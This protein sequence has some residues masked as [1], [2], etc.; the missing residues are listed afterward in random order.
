VGFLFGKQKMKSL[1]VCLFSNG[2]IKVGRGTRAEKRIKDHRARGETMG[3]EM[4]NHFI[5]ECPG[6]L[7]AA[8]CALI[9]WCSERC[10]KRMRSE[11]FIGVDYAQAVDKAQELAA[12]AYVKTQEEI[13]AG[14]ARGVAFYGALRGEIEKGISNIREPQKYTTMQDAVAAIIR[15]RDWMWHER[16]ICPFEATLIA[17]NCI[18]ASTTLNLDAFRKVMID[19]RDESRAN[20]VTTATNGS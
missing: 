6:D 11:W 3:I 12:N 18:E 4:V 19:A 15:V 14:D 5:A 2:I 7:Q 8:E 17:F 10:T 9:Q 13:D 20:N 1:Y 16:G